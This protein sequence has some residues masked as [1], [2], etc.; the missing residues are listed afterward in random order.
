MKQKFRQL[1]VWKIS[2]GFVK[3]VYR[4]TESFPKEEIYGLTGQLRR[5]AVSISLNIA[6]GSGA[7]TDKEFS[8]FLRISIRSAYEFF[9]GIE[10]AL[11]LGMLTEE[12]YSVLSVKCDK[13]SAMLTGLL[14]KLKA[15]IRQP[16]AESR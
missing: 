4:L 7:G 9:C 5:S 2:I 11:E 14:K 6:E 8:R 13:I 16:K 3:E 12:N 1:D 15:D 10:I